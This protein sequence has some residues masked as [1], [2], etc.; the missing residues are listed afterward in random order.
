MTWVVEGPGDEPTPDELD[1]AHYIHQLVVSALPRV[2]A[3]AV[4]WRNG[5]AGLFTAAVG[6]TLIRGRSDVGEL[7]PAASY[8]VGAL[9][10]AGFI[11]GALAAARFLRAAHG[12]PSIVRAETITA[13]VASEQDE[14]R[15][16]IEALRWGQRLAVLTAALLLAAVGLTWY[17][18]ARDD[19][20]LIVGTSSGQHCGDVETADAGSLALDTN[21]GRLTIDLDDVESMQPVAECP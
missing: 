11:A 3:T 17:G 19:P 10:L 2:R 6:F 13:R 16:S 15:A 18:P 5:M 9:L 20:Q 4:A 8:L 1:R 14:A 21:A 7:Q 12:M